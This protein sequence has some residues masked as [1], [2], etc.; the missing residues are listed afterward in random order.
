[1]VSRGKEAWGGAAQK[2]P[3]REDGGQEAEAEAED[4]D[5]DDD[6][7]EFEEL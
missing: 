5:E 2:A 6:S 1:M 7:D 3:E 4:V